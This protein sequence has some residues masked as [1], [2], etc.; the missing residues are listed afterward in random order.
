MK[1]VI[2]AAVA[3]IASPVF[4]GLT[5]EYVR[6]DDA[7]C[8]EITNLSN[9]KYTPQFAIRDE[10]NG[11]L[12]GESFLKGKPRF[13]VFIEDGH[14]KTVRKVGKSKVEYIEYHDSYEIRENKLQ[15][16]ARKGWIYS[17]DTQYVELLGRKS[18]GK[19]L[20][21][22]ADGTPNVKFEKQC[23]IISSWSL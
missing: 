16:I 13:N 11:S 22:G 6:V 7:T 4:A 18:N 20:P 3:L 9:R 21:M 2:I 12:Y 1:R 23:L 17:P 15:L 14:L 5:G 8:A 19:P 10:G